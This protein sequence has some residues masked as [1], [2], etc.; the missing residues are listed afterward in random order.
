MRRYSQLLKDTWWLWLLYLAVA[1]LM[2]GY[3]NKIFVI[4]L[5]ILVVIF[6]YFAIVRYDEDGTFRG[7]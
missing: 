5:P 1:G 2:I 7:P 4:M 6:L 3:V